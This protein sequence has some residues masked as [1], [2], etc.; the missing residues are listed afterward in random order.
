[1]DLHGE[2]IPYVS[3]EVRLGGPRIIARVPHGYARMLAWCECVNDKAEISV[4]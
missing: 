2:D 3:L 4:P 1:M